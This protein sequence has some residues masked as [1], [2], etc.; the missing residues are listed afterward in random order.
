[1]QNKNLSFLYFDETVRQ[2][3]R[4]ILRVSFQ[5]HTSKSFG[6]L[7][8]E[9]RSTSYYYVYTLMGLNFAGIIFHE[10][11]EFFENSRKLMPREN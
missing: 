6:S 5:W 3:V 4:T 11:R 8:N 1:M 2:L 9:T 10:F 7:L